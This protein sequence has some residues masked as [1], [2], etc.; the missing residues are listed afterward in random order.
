MLLIIPIIIGTI[1]YSHTINLIS[2]NILKENES[3]IMF[4]QNLIDQMEIE[5]ENI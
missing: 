5:L 3:K 1:I 2:S 4:I